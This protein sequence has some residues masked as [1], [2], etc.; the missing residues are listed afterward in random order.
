YQGATEEAMQQV[1][2][3]VNR[4][5]PALAMFNVKTLDTQT[6]ES[7]SREN[8]LALLSSYVAAF[9]LLLM[10]IGLFGL[11]NYSVAR[12]T[13]ELGLRMALGAKSATI[14]WMILRES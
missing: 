2:G 1:R 12:R 6:V 11:L 10:C 8:L 4:T 9:A 13:A 3:V 7:L 5:E 14:S